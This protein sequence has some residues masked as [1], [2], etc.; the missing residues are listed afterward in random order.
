MG[1]LTL[2]TGRPLAMEAEFA[3]YHELFE[4]DAALFDR[5]GKLVARSRPELTI[6]AD[7]QKGLEVALSGEQ[8]SL[9]DTIWPWDSRPLVVAAPVISGDETV[10]AA[11]T[12]SA[13]IKLRQYTLGTWCIFLSL[14][15]LALLSARGAVP[16]LARWILRPIVELDQTAKAIARGELSSRARISSGPA[17]LRG[18]VESFNGMSDIVEATIAKQR[19]FVSYASHQL[20]SPLT[21]IRLQLENLGAGLDGEDA[22]ELAAILDEVDRLGYL[23]KGLLA[24][25]HTESEAMALTVKDMAAIA[26]ERLTHWQATACRN[27]I[28]IRRTG[29]DSAVVMAGASVI[30]QVLDSFI[31]NAIKF[32]GCGAQVEVRV[33]A[34]ADGWKEAWVIDNGPGLQPDEHSRATEPFWRGPATQNIDGSGL[35]LAISATLAARCGGHVALRAVEPHGLAAGIRL[36]S[37]AGAVT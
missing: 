20:R 2:R 27:D 7:I 22:H 19:M 3:R 32:S 36:P 29:V 30:D 4:V 24:F 33:D 15:L 5:Y 8:P 28:A 35:G 23:C 37:A 1:E 34:G 25:A 11:V 13:T 9:R 12:I 6:T 18:L 17:E 10:G 16:W 26:D 14:S 21:V 31:E